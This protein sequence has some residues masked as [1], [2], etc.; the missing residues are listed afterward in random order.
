MWI[1]A[2]FHFF[3]FLN[4]GVGCR[5]LV[6]VYDDSN[7]NISG[8]SLWCGQRHYLKLFGWFIDWLGGPE[9]E[10]LFTAWLLSGSGRQQRSTL[11]RKL[12]LMQYVLQLD[13]LSPVSLQETWVELR[14]PICSISSKCRC[15]RALNRADLS[16]PC[17]KKIRNSRPSWN[18]KG[19]KSYLSDSGPSLGMSY[20]FLQNCRAAYSEGWVTQ[21]FCSDDI[22][23]NRLTR[24]RRSLGAPIRDRR[25][26][27]RS[28]VLLKYPGSIPCKAASLWGE[29]QNQILRCPCKNWKRLLLQPLDSVLRQISTAWWAFKAP[30][31]FR[32]FEY[33][34]EAHQVFVLTWQV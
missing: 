20:F 21:F 14:F 19:C 18:Q 30:W 22:V 17:W 31:T 10:Q 27:K 11:F 6:D 33:D 25:E 7:S 28:M 1:R 15:A 8:A 4:L 16:Q 9:L 24:R 23:Q 13:I 26:I 34:L 2:F 12:S 5:T 29:W 32:V 3:S